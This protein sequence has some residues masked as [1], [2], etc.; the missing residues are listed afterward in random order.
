MACYAISE[1][2]ELT[3]DY[4]SKYLKQSPLWASNTECGLSLVHVK[5]KPDFFLSFFF[6]FPFLPFLTENTSVFTSKI[7]FKYKAPLLSFQRQNHLDISLKH[8]HPKHLEETNR[9]LIQTSHCTLMDVYMIECPSTSVMI[10]VWQNM[11]VFN[12][13]PN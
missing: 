7:L 1:Q 8:G 13:F 5:Y 11:I 2:E 10:E 12:Q 6:F 9:T 4:K 3:Q